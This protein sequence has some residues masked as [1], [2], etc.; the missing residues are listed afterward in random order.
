[1]KTFTVGVSSA[2]FNEFACFVQSRPYRE[3]M[4]ELVRR[5]VQGIILGCTEITLLVG[6]QDTSVPVFDS[7]RIHVEGAVRWMLAEPG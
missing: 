5:G 7:T 4:A 6:A 3:I 2:Q 1:M